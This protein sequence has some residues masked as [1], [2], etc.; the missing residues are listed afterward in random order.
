[1]TK[2]KINADEAQKKIAEMQKVL[3]E[4]RS[5]KIKELTSNL[6]AWLKENKAKLSYRVEVIDGKTTTNIIVIPL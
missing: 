1:M 3:E 2:E 4:E 5:K 6:N